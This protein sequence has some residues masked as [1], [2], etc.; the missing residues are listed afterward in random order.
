M[1]QLLHCEDLIAA[2]P[3]SFLLETE[4]FIQ[5]WNGNSIAVA[6]ICDIVL[7][8]LVNGTAVT[9]KCHFSPQTIQLLC[10]NSQRFL[11]HSTVVERIFSA[12][13]SIV[14][15]RRVA[16]TQLLLILQTMLSAAQKTDNTNVIEVIGSSLDDIVSASV[17]AT[18]S[19]IPNNIMRTLIRH[20]NPIDNPI[21]GANQQVVRAFFFLHSNACFDCFY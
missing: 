8:S 12:L 15:N 7:L 11:Y 18:P 21:E 3:H 13:G 16:S 10:H 1:Q 4:T 9:S 2:S 20:L 5:K 17:A 14:E 6:H 19:Q